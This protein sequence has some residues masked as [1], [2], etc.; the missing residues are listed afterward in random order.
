MLWA[1]F[2]GF[3]QLEGCGGG[4]ALYLNED[5]YFKLKIGLGR[6]TNNYV[7][8]SNLRLLL[9]SSLEKGRQQLQIFCNSKII[10][11]WFNQLSNCHVNT[12][13]NLMEE[14]I[15]L[16]SQFDSVICRHIYRERNEWV[17][18]SLYL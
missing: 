10:I 2:D 7:E 18:L 13:I 3:S 12:L 4:V 9:L 16:K 6:G 11:N 1:H 17:C 15:I 14:V 5:Q 8:L